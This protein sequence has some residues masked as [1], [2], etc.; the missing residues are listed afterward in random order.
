MIENNPMPPCLAVLTLAEIGGEDVTRRD[1]HL[2][3]QVRHFL[4]TRVQ[5]TEH[6]L[7]HQRRVLTNLLL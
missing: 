4:W 2:L 1:Q 3:A 7:D 5:Q 6:A